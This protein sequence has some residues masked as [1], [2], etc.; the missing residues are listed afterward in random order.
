MYDDKDDTEKAGTM[1]GS[2]GII[3]L[4]THF[5]RFKG[6]IGN[7]DTWPFEVVFR[8]V[9]GASASN[10]VGATREQNLQPF[11]DA[12]VH[13]QNA[14]VSGITT[15]C[16]FL[17]L[18]QAQIAAHLTVPFVA[19][20]LVQVPWVQSIIPTGKTVGILT[21]NADALTSAHLLAAGI[22]GDVPVQGTEHGEEFTRCI[23]GDQRM[24]NQSLCERDNV[25][26]AV[27]L[28]DQHPDLG[29]I[30]MECTNMAPYASAVQQ[31]TGLPVYSIYTLIRWFHA[32]LV[33]AVH[34][35]QLMHGAT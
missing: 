14:G 21:I 9:M 19:S 22:S 1:N 32:G 28:L 5:P 33:P 31:A 23:L 27:Q 7:P 35:P 4:D 15:S 34:Q 30:V 2:I 13:L 16:G 10:V 11:I 26:A 24:M 3:M 29:A 8:T 17:S 6:D 12:A 18:A 20:S 25:N